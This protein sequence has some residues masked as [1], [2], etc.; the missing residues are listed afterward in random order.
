MPAHLALPL[1]V[2]YLYAWQWVAGD[3]AKLIRPFNPSLLR[4]L[5]VPRYWY[6]CA[7]WCVFLYF[8]LTFYLDCYSKIFGGFIFLY[9]LLKVTAIECIKAFD[10]RMEMK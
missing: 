4:S 7:F 9:Y 1:T 10:E 2:V 8:G 3:Y 6:W 5:M